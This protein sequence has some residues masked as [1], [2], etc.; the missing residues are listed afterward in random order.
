MSAQH[1]WF[2]ARLARV[3]E[4]LGYE[5][6]PEHYPTFADVYVTEPRY[7]LE[8]QRWSTEFAARTKERVGKGAKVLWMLTED[9]TSRR[10]TEALF[11]LPAVRLKVVSRW[12]HQIQ[13][14]PWENPEQNRDAILIVYGTVARRRLP[15]GKFQTSQMDALQFLKEV[16]EGNRS[17]VRPSAVNHGV[18]ALQ[19]DVQAHS[20]AR[21]A[22]IRAQ[23][24]GMKSQESAQPEERRP[25]QPSESPAISDSQGE[26]A[27]VAPASPDET[28]EAPASMRMAEVPVDETPD[29]GSPRPWWR[30]MLNWL[31]EG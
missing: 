12:N 21:L 17:W 2:E 8:V 15:T 9:A 24:E 4:V 30:R 14:Q 5:A 22:R 27:P 11:T 31:I 29:P 23:T 19:P 1:R 7:C 28:V 20:L 6:I 25:K 13:L 3:C 16:F 26:D 10:V 18:W